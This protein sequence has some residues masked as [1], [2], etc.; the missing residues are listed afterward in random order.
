MSMIGSFGLCPKE[1]YEKL[2]ELI[3]KDALD[4][5]DAVINEISEELAKSEGALENDQCSGEVFLALFDYFSTT[6]GVHIRGGPVQGRICEKWQEATGDFDLAALRDKDRL[7]FLEKAID[8]EK[9]SQF[10][11]DFFQA[12]Y[13]EAGKT[14]YEVLFSNLRKT[15]EDSILIWHLY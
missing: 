10:I 3:E 13:G 14:A 1:K 7:L 12:D 4:A 11:S 2:V 6:F 15:G 5:A 9:L 8:C